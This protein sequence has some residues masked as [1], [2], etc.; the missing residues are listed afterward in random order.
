M[1]H[2]RGKIWNEAEAVSSVP[3]FYFFG[4]PSLNK[5]LVLINT[6]AQLP[7]LPCLSPPS[8]LIF[9]S[10]SPPCELINSRKGFL[11]LPSIWGMTPLENGWRIPLQPTVCAGGG[12]GGLHVHQNVSVLSS[13]V[14]ISTAKLGVCGQGCQA[15]P[16]HIGQSEA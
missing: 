8:T 10:F 15:V 7:T 9:C 3:F 11:Q 5:T 1:S 4:A 16:G 12:A 6:G 14:L 13:V 2:P